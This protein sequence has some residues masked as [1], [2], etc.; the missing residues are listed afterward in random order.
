MEVIDCTL[1]KKIGVKNPGSD[2]CI[3]CERKGKPLPQPIVDSGHFVCQHP[4]CKEHCNT[5]EITINLDSMVV[6]EFGEE[7]VKEAAQII[8]KTMF[9]QKGMMCPLHMTS[10][11]GQA[12]DDVGYSLIVAIHQQRKR[13]DFEEE[14][15]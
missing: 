1:C 4:G 12:L 3:Q 6:D 10:F 2:E 15:Q 11:I 13:K 9:V 8:V 14:W 7:D 5:G